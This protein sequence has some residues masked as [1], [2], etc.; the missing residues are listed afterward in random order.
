M[1]IFKFNEVAGTFFFCSAILQSKGD[2]LKVAAGLVVAAA[3]SAGAGLNS[4]AN[5][6]AVVE[7]ANAQAGAFTVVS[8][9]LGA[10]LA[11]QLNNFFNGERKS[12]QKTG[13]LVKACAGEFLGTLLLSSCAAGGDTMQTAM[14]L[15]VACNTFTGDFNPA[16]TF[17]TFVNTNDGDVQ[18]LGATVGA[19]V[20]GWI[21]AAQ[22]A[23]FI[24]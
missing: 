19:Q 23:N 17:M 24:R 4:A 11:L 1:D 22:L 18:R 14:G 16:V 6:A 20:C 5:L 21:A 2:S 12:D 15:Y 7:G 13:D 8:Q 10:F 9:L 3:V